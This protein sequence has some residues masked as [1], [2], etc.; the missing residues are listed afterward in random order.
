MRTFSHP[1]DFAEAA[2]PY[3]KKHPILCLLQR[4]LTQGLICDWDSSKKVAVRDAVMH[5]HSAGTSAWFAL[6]TNPGRPIILAGDAPPDEADMVRL[7]SLYP[8]L[9]GV[10]GERQLSY[11]FAEAYGR[12]FRLQN[13]LLLYA[14]SRE[15][16][17]NKGF[18]FPGQLRLASLEELELAAQWVKEFVLFI[19]E[20]GDGE[21]YQ[22][23]A[24]ALI[25][26]KHLYFYCL[27]GQPV[28]MAASTRQAGGTAA[29]NYV[30]TPENWRGRGF[31]TAG[32]GAL[33]DRLLMKYDNLM[34]YADANYPASNAV[35]LKLGFEE[36]GVGVELVFE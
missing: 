28:T 2:L 16:W 13:D 30:F 25:E 14:L 3:W 17:S 21:D 12:P 34:L 19:R 33:C 8:N 31:A 4:G 36:C 9:K 29:I 35:Y 1:A 24:R 10:N 27:D 26:A 20:V 18:K 15:A 23:R 32:V 11:D 22:E 7:R 5:A 6:Q